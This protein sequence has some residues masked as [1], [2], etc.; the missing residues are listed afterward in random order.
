MAG[1]KTRDRTAVHYTT[2]VT[3]YRQI[4][5]T[6]T[7]PDAQEEH[8]IDLSESMLAFNSVILYIAASNTDTFT[9]WVKRGAAWYSLE[10]ITLGADNECVV[11]EN[12]PATQVYVQAT[13][14]ADSAV[15]REEHSL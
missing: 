13:G 15:I 3:L 7:A 6:D 4:T 14:L 9:V 11:L 10:D 2:P 5:S 8:V 1:R 12:V